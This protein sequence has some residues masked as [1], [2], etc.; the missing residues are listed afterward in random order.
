MVTTTI[1]RQTEVVALTERVKKRKDEYLSAPVRICAERSRLVTEAWK[2]TEGEPLI[3]RR[4]RAFQK[5][6]EGISVSIR[7]GE[8]IVGSQTRYIRGSGPA[9]DYRP[10]DVFEMFRASKL[11]LQGVAPAEVSE[12][13]KESLLADAAYW[14]TR[15]ASDA[16]STAEHEVFGSTIDLLRESRV[17]SGADGRPTSPR[18]VDYGKVLDKGLK[19]I[20]EEAEKRL[21]RLTFYEAKDADRFYFLKAAI[22]CCKALVSLAHRY[23]QRAGEMARE[24]TDPVR[25]RELEEIADICRR[26]PE[27]PARSFQ[28]AVQSFW[29]VHLAVNLEPASDCETPG[30]LDQYLYPFYERD[31]REGQIT[32]QEAAELLGC[33]WVKFVEREHVKGA[34]VKDTAMSSQYQDVTIGGVTSDGKDATNDLT[35]LILEVTRQLRTAQPPIYLRCHS[36]TPEELWMKAV[37]VNLDRGDGMPAF[38]NDQAVLLNLVGRGV[39]LPEARGWA[40]IGCVLPVVPHACGCD[41]FLIFSTC[42]IF[43]IA[44][45]NGVDPRTGKEVGLKTGDPRDFRSFEELYDAFKTQFEYFLG[46]L[47]RR[48]NLY[49]QVRNRYYDL[50]FTS[51]LID[52]CIEHGLSYLQGGMRYPQL[53]WGVSD[54]GNQNLA[55]SLGAIKKLVFE[56]KT[57]EMG[58]LLGALKANFEGKEKLRQMLLAAPKY[59]NDDDYAD[60]V[61]DDLS[62]WLQRR[63][64]QEKHVLGHPVRLGRGGSTQHYAMGKM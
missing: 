11:T 52:D 37:Q 41:T 19:G 60:Q 25:K 49:K 28:E 53:S 36:G 38:L 30:R 9:V 13:E 51:A 16:A 20:I 12:A 62:L 21:A 46:V 47:T 26:V 40:G 64:G 27:N 56:D 63:W 57:I 3:M 24:E 5:I 23:A 6:M 2:E 61:F 48:D 39:P 22:I 14:K 17:V 33:L 58:E 10:D 18:I 34:L 35:Y 54:R 4:A 32:P 29:F 15:S 31:M 43:E 50:P 42:K 45:N 8:L 7:D 55:D 59:G 44:L 1:G